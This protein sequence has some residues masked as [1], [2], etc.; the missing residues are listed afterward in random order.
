[1]SWGRHDLGGPV[2]LR[3]LAENDIDGPYVSWFADPEV[4]EF[5]E[6]RDI[7]RQDAIE[8][9]RHGNRT[10][11]YFM[12]AICLA[13]GDRHIGNLKIGP[14]DRRHMT[15]DMVTVIGDRAAWGKGY[16]R[17]AIRVGIKLAFEEHN[18]RKLSASIDSANVGSIKA[19][20]AAG[21]EIET[22]LKDQFMQGG[23]LTDKVYVAYF[24][25]NF[26]PDRNES[27]P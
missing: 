17:E 14:I 3:A 10:R 26:R 15:S 12:H 11:L 24:N 5:L 9:L 20:T 4:T 18:I 27:T 8:N 19:Y 16:A 22:R 21:F 7:S 23:K 2:Y 13:E 25:P 1:M 6:A